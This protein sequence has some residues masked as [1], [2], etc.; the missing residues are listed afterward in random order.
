MCLQIMLHADD[1]DTKLTNVT[2]KENFKAKYMKICL[3]V[4]LEPLNSVNVPN[5]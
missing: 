3:K 2:R 4:P 5:L 1:W